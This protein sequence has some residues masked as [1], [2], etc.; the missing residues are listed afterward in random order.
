MRKKLIS[1]TYLRGIDKY[2]LKLLFE[3]D[4]Y[5]SI[6][7]LKKV[8]SP[9]ILSTGL[10]LINDG[11]YIVEIIPKNENYSVRAFI[12][13]EKKLLQYYIDISLGN[14]LDEET[15][16]PYYDD[17]F[18]DIIITN[19]QIDV[20]DGDELVDAL[21]QKQIS[22]DDYNLAIK[23][24]DELIKEIEKNNNKYLNMDLTKLL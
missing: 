16:I 11:Y 1:K 19:G 13:D 18:L 15:K 22:V 7:E 14:G 4:C 20:V 6:K 2:N 17:L 3:D 8:D 10:C 9:F 24:K 23:V 12:D 21:N 5:Y